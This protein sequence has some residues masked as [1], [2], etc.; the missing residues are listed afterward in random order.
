MNLKKLIL[1]T[2]L[3]FSLSAL[4][5]QTKKA[6]ENFIG[7]WS[8]DGFTTKMIIFVRN[9][10]LDAIVIDWVHC[11]ELETLEIVILS[12]NKILISTKFP[13][14]SHTTI[15]NLEIVNNDKLKETIKGDA[16]G[17]LFWNRIK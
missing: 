2:V 9:D 17:V 12:E 16:D 15:S 6:N 4:F 7:Y 1:S 10:K 11:E 3:L 5:G 13:T 8:L 14:N